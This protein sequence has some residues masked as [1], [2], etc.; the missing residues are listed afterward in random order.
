MARKAASRRDPED[1]TASRKRLLLFG[2]VGL[3]VLALLV[4]LLIY[5]K[6]HA[7][8][9]L[10]RDVQRRIRATGK[11]GETPSQMPT[12]PGAAGAPSA[13]TVPAGTPPLRQQLAQL[14]YAGRSGDSRPQ[15]LYVT[16][17]ELNSMLADSF[18]GDQRIR[19]VRSYFGSGAA[20]MVAVV[21]WKGQTLTVTVTTEP[22]VVNGGLQ[23][24]VQKVNVGSLSAP[25]AIVERVQGAVAKNS[26]KF[27]P[28][29]TGLYVE[30]VD[31]RDGVAIL[32]GR[33]VAKR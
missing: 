30:Q 33:A 2:C 20:Y 29:R 12:A 13:A 16:D 11:I 9:A 31:I 6:I 25:G 18:K 14:E 21:N 4:F 26:G 28:E 27:A 32:S 8:P 10:P 19:E 23:F 24:A 7:G 22:V 5:F 15:T 17:A 3:L 1:T